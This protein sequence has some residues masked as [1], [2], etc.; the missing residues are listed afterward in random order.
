MYGVA[1]QETAVVRC[2][3]D[4]IPPVNKKKINFFFWP[5]Y[6][7]NFHPSGEFLPL[8]IQYVDIGD[9]G[10]KRQSNGPD[11]ESRGGNWR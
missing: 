9:N 3:T 8:G 6:K 5:S 7:N 4:A 10:I 11:G 1:K 2:Q